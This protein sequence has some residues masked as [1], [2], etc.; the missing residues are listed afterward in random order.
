MSSTNFID[1][2]RGNLLEQRRNLVEW[3]TTTATKT[4]QTRLGPYDEAALKNHLQTLDTA[5]QKTDD[6]TLGLCTVCHDYVE[7]TRLEMDY[8]ACVCL[9]HMTG[10]QKARLEAELE[11]SQK[12]QKA[13]LPQAIPP[14]AGLDLA[15]YSQPAQIVGG[16]YF[17]FFEFRN[18][19]FG[20][21][22]GDVMGKGMPASLLMANLQAS[23]RILVKDHDTPHET[24]DR[25]N[26]IF[27]H[28]VRLTKFVTLFLGKYDATNRVLSYSNAGHNPPA[29]WRE[30]PDGGSLSWLSPNGAAVGLVEQS[31]F[32][33]DTVRLQL[34][35][36]L[37]FYTDGFS[38][39]LNGREEE[40][41][42][43]RIAAAARDNRM[44]PA[45]D[46]VRHIKEA[47]RT[48][49]QDAPLADDRTLLVFKVT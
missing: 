41:G 1:R 40:F 34:G 16:D 10:D 21:T 36:V 31:V 25:L 9:E 29:L 5:L 45:A 14:I 7:A 27:C 24:L 35:D 20:F 8:T 43:E 19:H 13:L 42:E 39:A 17:D 33:T 28:N 18:G 26:A 38:E 3:L 48:H 37:I 30:G 22:V 44:A 6:K 46:I 12:V 15:V 23:L 49:T 2:L 32:Q 47:V 4:K 11:L